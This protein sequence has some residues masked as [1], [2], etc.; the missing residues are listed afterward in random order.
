MLVRIVKDWDFIDIFRQTPDNCGIWNGVQFTTEEIEEFDG[1]LVLNSPHKEIKG[2]CG[3]GNKIL[4]MQEP[5][6]E[7]YNWHKKS[8]K[9]FNTVLTQFSMNRENCLLSQPA[10]PWHVSLNYNELIRLTPESLNKQDKVS[11]ITSSKNLI[12]GHELRLSFIDFL[13]KNLN[14]DLYGRGFK[15]IEKKEEGLLN[16]K[17]SIAF[18]NHSGNF[19][20]TEKISDCFL[21]YTM[22]IYYG[23]TN[24][25]QYFPPQSLIKIDPHN[26]E[27]AL[28]I[29][30]EAVQ[31]N[32]WQNNLEYIKEARELV[33]KKHQIFPYI[34]DN[35]I[36]KT[37]FIKEKIDIPQNYWSTQS[38]L[39]LKLKKRILNSFK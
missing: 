13:N 28:K 32:L 39:F 2:L 16:Y 22:P 18:E 37:D 31:N 24:I 23:C 38:N 36:K 21:T 19:Y 9:Y 8:F 10:L 29:I 33:L 34:T 6:V 1:L 3:K 4:I 30:N 11:W 20:W 15:E 7:R 5:P 25:E 17:Y 12:K 35:F 27:K 26:P 14:Y